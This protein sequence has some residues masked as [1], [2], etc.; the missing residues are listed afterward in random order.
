[1]GHWQP[2]CSVCFDV[3]V[4]PPP[5]SRLRG[6]VIPFVIAFVFS[7]ATFIAA[8]Q[9]R[10]GTTTTTVPMLLF[11]FIGS[12]ASSDFSVLHLFVLPYAIFAYLEARVETVKMLHPLMKQAVM[13]MIFAIFT[14][15]LDLFGASMDQLLIFSWK[16]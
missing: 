7:L 3:V 10:F 6:G 1:V 12:L 2:C 15:C 4:L 13:V 5:S 11:S 9:Y 14:R 8:R 16:S